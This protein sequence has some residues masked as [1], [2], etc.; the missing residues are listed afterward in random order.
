MFYDSSSITDYILMPFSKIYLA[1][2]ISLFSNNIAHD[3]SGL[4]ISKFAH[5]EAWTG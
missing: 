4:T 5:Y 3:N 1:A 2:F